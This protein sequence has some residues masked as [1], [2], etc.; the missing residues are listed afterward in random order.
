MSFSVAERDRINARSGK[1]L[2]KNV[3]RRLRRE[4][5]MIFG[6]TR[7]LSQGCGVGSLLTVISP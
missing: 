4:R 3:H 6:V 7:L 2:I 1:R 5:V